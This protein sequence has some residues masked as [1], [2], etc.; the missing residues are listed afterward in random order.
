VN[1]KR[2]EHIRTEYRAHAD[3]ARAIMTWPRMT[4]ARELAETEAR[5]VARAGSVR[6]LRE[7]MRRRESWRVIRETVG[8]CLSVF[9]GIFLFVS[10]LALVHFGMQENARRE[11][12]RAH[13]E[14][15]QSR[16][17]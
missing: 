6:E 11:A 9:T 15:L 1:A 8:T 3:M 12:M 13:V 16:G 14:T 17:G 4:A 5:R 10:L 2:A 7:R